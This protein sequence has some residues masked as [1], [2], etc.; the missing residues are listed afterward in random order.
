M[1][2]ARQAEVY[3]VRS[4]QTNK[5]SFNEDNPLREKVQHKIP[6]APPPPHN[7]SGEEGGLHWNSE[8]II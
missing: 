8:C 4:W 2:F 1:I 5:F 6:S 7:Y 3:F